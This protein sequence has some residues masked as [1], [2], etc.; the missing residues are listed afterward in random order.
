MIRRLV[1]ALIAGAALAAAFPAAASAFVFVAFSVG[2]GPTAR[3]DAIDF[4]TESPL[5]VELVRDGATLAS[6]PAG[7]VEVPMLKPGDTVR[8]SSDGTTVVA[9]AT[10]DGT[11]AL[12]EVCIGTSSFT[13]TRPPADRTF[14]AGAGRIEDAE[15][16][17]MI[18]SSTSDGSPAVVTLARPLAAGDAAFAQGLVIT[19]DLFVGTSQLVA[20]K[21]CTAAEQL[22]QRNPGPG[23]PDSPQGQRPRAAPLSAALAAAKLKRLG[24]A[25]LARGRTHKLPVALSQPGTVRFK[26]LARGKVIGAGKKTAAAGVRRVTVKLTAAGLRLLKGTKRLKLTLRGTFTPSRAGEVP[27]RASV[28]FTLR[29]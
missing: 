24:L 11:P 3:V 26:L 9:T 5:H 25:R 6:S 23:D 18:E 19:E 28:R 7:F 27:Q 2:P 1:T 29:R 10:Y 21:E 4:D 22:D 17:A 13:V 14:E 16:N 8:A 20:A 15:E 12:G